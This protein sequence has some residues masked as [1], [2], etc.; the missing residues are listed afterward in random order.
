MRAKER[1]KFSEAQVSASSGL[2][3]CPERL[4]VLFSGLGDPSVGTNP[5][6]KHTG[7]LPSSQMLV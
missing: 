2:V 6:W 5:R 1:Q 7:W 3:T 4:D